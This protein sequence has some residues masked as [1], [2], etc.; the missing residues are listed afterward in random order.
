MAAVIVD[1][2]ALSA[3]ERYRWMTGVIVP[4]PIA[5]VLTRAG[6]GHLNLAPF[7]Y[8][9]AVASE[10]PLVVLSVGR[11][12]GAHA[13]KDTARNVLAHRRFVVHIPSWPMLEAMNA[14]SLD[15]PP[16]RSELDL[17][18]LAT[19]PFPGFPLPR[20]AGARVAMGCVL[21]QAQRIGRQT[22]V[23]GRIERLFVDDAVLRDGAPDAQA[24]DPVA[25]L[26]A[27][28]YARLGEVRRLARP[29]EERDVRL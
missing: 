18:R 8:F 6:D 4:R 25:R 26:G 29:K 17:A 22:L 3:R 23:F 28:A 2:A 27:D 11:R 7:S 16:E 14:T 24:L 20:L 13:P 15:L 1:F 5:W 21:A 19:A 12:P 10:P 9:N